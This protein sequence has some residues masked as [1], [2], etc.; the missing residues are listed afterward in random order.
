MLGSTAYVATL[1]PAERGIEAVLDNDIVGNEL[2]D[3][4]TRVADRIRVFATREDNSPRSGARPARRRG[5]RPPRPRVR[6]GYDSGRRSQRAW[7]R[8]HSVSLG[9]VCC[10]APRRRRRNAKK[11]AQRPRH[12]RARVDPLLGAG[13]PRQR[14]GNRDAGHQWHRTESDRRD[15]ASSPGSNFED[16]AGRSKLVR[17]YHR[18][19]TKPRVFVADF[20][21]H[22]NR[23]EIPM[24]KGSCLCGKITYAAKVE[25]NITKCHC[26]IC[27]KVSGSAYGNYATA[28]IDSFKW[29]SGEKLLTKYESSAR[30]LPKFLLRVRHSHADRAT[31]RWV[32]ISFSPA[33]STAQRRAARRGGAHVPAV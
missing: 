30:Q 24:A 6:G 21:P 10:R 27:Q 19:P 16:S 15:R 12:A 25:P 13:G 18:G 1:S 23:A 22:D 26:K 2:G 5:N 9:R 3:D 29:T 4:G 31:P 14:R 8:P 7:Q 20:Q 33:R 11:P 32:S 28:P 17:D